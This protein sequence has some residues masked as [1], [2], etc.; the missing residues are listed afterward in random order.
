[1]RAA[2]LVALL[3]LA[4]PAAGQSIGAN[5]AGVVTDT[6]GARVT[7]A[8]LTISNVAN[9][10]SQTLTAGEQGEFR[11]VALPPAPYRLVVE[12]PGFARSERD[13]VLNVGSEATLEVRLTVAGVRETI[14]VTPASFDVAKSQPSSLVTSDDIGT[15]PEIGRNF[16]VL[17]QLLPGAG[18][19]NTTPGRFA[20]TK[21]GGAADQRSA[22]TTMVDGGDVDDT[23]WGSPTINVTQEG[24]QEFRVFRHQFDAQYGN[25]LNA[26]V[27]V[28]TRAG[29]NQF[30]GSAFYFGRDD[31]LN[32]RN[33]FAQRKPPFDEQRFGAT[34]GGPLAR[35]RTHLFG[36]YE[37]DHVDTARIIALPASNPFAIRENGIFPARADEHMATLR[38]DHQI[39]NAHTAFV[40]YTHDD[41]ASIRSGVAPSSDS[42]Q[43]DTF[44]RARS[45]VGEIDS[46]VSTR[47]LNTLRVHWFAHTSEGTPHTLERTPGVQRPSVS[48]GQ[49]VGG[50]W[51]TLSRTRLTLFDALYVSG[52]RHDLKF[53]GEISFGTNELDA[54]FFEDGFFTFR[55]DLPF[56]PN[57]QVTWPTSFQ[58]Q[59]PNVQTYRARQL[60]LFIQDDWRAAT[61]LRLNLGLRYDLDPTLRINAFYE[62]LLSRP[63]LARLREFVSDDRGTDLNNL[64]P[65]LGATYDLRGDGRIVLRGGWGMYVARNRP[66][67]QLRSM[68][69]VG[70]PATLVEDSTRLRLYPD[71]SAILAGGAPLQLGSVIPDDFVQAYAL[72]TTIGTAWQLGRAAFLD[73][74]YVHSYADHQAGFTDRNIPSSGTISATNPRPV[75][76]F[77]QVWML[78]NFSKSWYD[79]LEVQLRMNMPRQSGLRASYTLSRGYLDGVDFFNTV[80][81]TQRT[82]RERGYSPSDQRHNLTA[83]ASFPLPW[84][85]EISAILKL[86]SGSPMPVQAGAGLDLDGDR[87]A[88]GDRPPGL[89]ITVGRDNVEESLRIINEFRAALTLPPVNPDLLRLDPY[90]SLDVRLSKVFQVRARQR[91]ELTLEAF[92]LTNHVNYN[93][94]SV[95][96]NLNSTAF[97]ERRTARDARQIQW[98]V[99]YLF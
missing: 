30:Q 94:T 73:V 46:T 1:M 4:V 34:V 2:A 64:Q 7:G 11:I 50:D 39:S 74:D 21:F 13:L 71:I 95:N 60:A 70:A 58:Q 82:P 29:G 3:G 38:L 12:S 61:R 53:G 17:A 56:D 78:E 51:Q 92:N 72:N 52:A 79:A 97:L 45:I 35:N 80:R 10:R 55:S 42:S 20:T 8:T 83:A 16:L 6:S 44:S 86:I 27:S 77:T 54:H 37:R 5:I 76:E 41:Q 18:P 87:S 40:R 63:A 96:R 90:R 57:S 66:W 81:G 84:Q 31:T 19:L 33:A 49:T 25:A 93:S 24:V 26:V 89:A 47:A 43:V 15:L 23:Q 99:R 62:D 14:E 88:T 75:R 85:L 69:Q 59:P 98:G 48:T 67:F 36:T 68:N 9:G 32:A 28:V 91:L 22:F 65:R